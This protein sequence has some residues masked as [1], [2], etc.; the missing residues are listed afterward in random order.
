M[1]N[2]RRSRIVSESH[3]ALPEASNMP[4]APD[5]NPD[6]IDLIHGLWLELSEALPH[7]ELH[8]S[9]VLTLALQHLQRQFDGPE[10]AGILAGIRRM[11]TQHSEE[12]LN[13]ALLRTGTTAFRIDTPMLKPFIEGR[14]QTRRIPGHAP[15]LQRAGDRRRR[16]QVLSFW[17]AVLSFCIPIVLL[18]GVIWNPSGIKGDVVMAS[19]AVLVLARL[20]IA[21]V[22]RGAID[23]RDRAWTVDTVP[24]R[25]AAPRSGVSDR[26]LPDQ[27]SGLTDLT[28]VRHHP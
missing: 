3:A 1:W 26:T 15:S 9:D 17:G 5:L 23:R 14:K 6:D 8:H 7:A 19:L 25:G 22:K 11:R 4:A 21:L 20:G 27:G 16:N 28:Y 2:W 13:P 12:R 18:I 24:E 10:K